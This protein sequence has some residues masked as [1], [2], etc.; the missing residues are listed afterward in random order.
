VEASTKHKSEDLRISW[1]EHTS[2]MWQC[3]LFVLWKKTWRVGLLS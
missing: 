2:L 3:K 1:S